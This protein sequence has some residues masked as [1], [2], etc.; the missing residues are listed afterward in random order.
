MTS[1]GILVGALFL[2][3]LHSAIPNHW[4]P[5]VLVGRARGWSRRRQAVITFSAGFLHSVVTFAIG[6]AIA[7]AGLAIDG[8]AARVGMHV[9]KTVASAVL[10]L[11]GLL[12]IL[13]RIFGRHLHGH[14]NP[15]SFSSSSDALL[16][17]ALVGMLSL[18]PCAEILPLY[19]LAAADGWESVVALSTV[20]VLATSIGMTGIV[21]FFGEKLSKMRWKWIEEN[22]GLFAGALLVALGVFAATELEEALLPAALDLGRWG[23]EILRSSWDIFKDAAP[24]ILFG[25][26]SGGVVYAFIRPEGVARYLGKGRYRPV[27]N[28]A[29]IGVP[30]P[31]CSCGVIPAAL[32]LRRMGATR[33]ATTAF[34]ITTP[35][36]GIDS[37]AVT[38]ALLGPIY[39]V[40]RPIAAFVT[41]VVAGVMEVL[42]GE[43]ETA[44]RQAEVGGACPKCE[45]GGPPDSAKPVAPAPPTSVLAKMKLAVTYG[46]GDFLDDISLWLVA[47]FLAAG[48]ILVLVPPESIE[49]TLGSGLPGMIAVLVVSIPLYI[50][51]SATTP[52]AAALLMKGASPGAALVLL[53][54]G[55][56]SNTAGI[57]LLSKFLG[58][59]S[60][61][62]YLSSIIVCSLGFGLLLN[63]IYSRLGLTPSAMMGAH[64]SSGADLFHLVCAAALLGLVS[65]HLFR[66]MAKSLHGHAE[67]DH[68]AEGGAMEHG[69]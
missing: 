9:L 18:S 65:F 23:L 43:K 10:I 4:G 32:T 52:M 17:S 51:A 60:V 1:P 5:F 41:G 28:A 40:F 24:Y 6:I 26:L 57:V 39:A 66:R 13:G 22:G 53:L 3:V 67:A 64:H 14:F 58:K 7:Y 21:L 61:L 48:L 36:T 25:C 63:G 49:K 11:M 69:D 50:C 29:L 31:L 54:A 12:L 2:S 33:G 35:E 68:E 37:I 19:L 56:A 34:L 45:T 38:Y 47:G 16:I 55:P 27:V 30:L 62:I 8:Q 42:F 20:V 46:L 44:P 59:R 15:S